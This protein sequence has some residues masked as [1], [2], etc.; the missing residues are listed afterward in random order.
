VLCRSWASVVV[1]EAGRFRGH[2]HSPLGLTMRRVS[3]RSTTAGKSGV[4]E[5]ADGGCASAAGG[6]QSDNQC[7]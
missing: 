1:A 3:H 2:G 7:L 5:C 4:P 6:R